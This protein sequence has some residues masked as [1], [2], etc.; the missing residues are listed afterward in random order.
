MKL[1]HQIA[2]SVLTT[3]LVVFALSVLPTFSQVLAR[4]RERDRHMPGFVERE[5]R[6]FLECGVL[7]RG[8][9]IPH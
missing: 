4:Q 9:V 1:C 5:F 2:H 3:L 8:S 6:E 7:A